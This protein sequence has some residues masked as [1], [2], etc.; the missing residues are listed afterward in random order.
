MTPIEIMAKAMEDI[1]NRPLLLTPVAEHIAQ[2]LEEAGFAIVPVE[3]TDHMIN[4]GFVAAGKHVKRTEDGGID[5][6]GS[7]AIAC[8]KA[9]LE[10]AKAKP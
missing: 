7:G 9:M 1:D 3:P 6:Y 4:Q 2:A 5:L 10:V 8:Y